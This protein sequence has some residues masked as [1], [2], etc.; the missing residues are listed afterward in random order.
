VHDATLCLSKNG[1]QFPVVGK[2]ACCFVPIEFVLDHYLIDIKIDALNCE[3]TSFAIGTQQRMS[4]NPSL[5]DHDRFPL[6]L[7]R[8]QG[9]MLVG[10]EDSLPLATA[11]KNVGSF[12]P[13]L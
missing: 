12:E 9:N 8:E 13:K 4:W 2:R 3:S 1:A 5:R 11:T 7:R 6:S 10:P